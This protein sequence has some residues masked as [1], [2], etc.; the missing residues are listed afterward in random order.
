MPNMACSSF[1]RSGA[2]DK[3]KTT[4]RREIWGGYANGFGACTALHYPLGCLYPSRK[5]GRPSKSSSRLMARFPRA[6]SGL[7]TK[8][9]HPTRFPTHEVDIRGSHAG[10]VRPDRILGQARTSC[11]CCL[12]LKYQQGRWI[13]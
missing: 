4:A 7:Q 11:S 6:S 3:K 9:F 1:I 10:E 12:P 13:M 5:H 8:T 2:A